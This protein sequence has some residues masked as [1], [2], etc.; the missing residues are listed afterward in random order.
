MSLLLQ[1]IVLGIGATIVI[2]VW[3]IVRRSWPGVSQPN[4]GL[5][6]RWLIGVMRGR[7]RLSTEITSTPSRLELVCGWVAHYAIGIG[8]AGMLLWTA[9]PSWVVEPTLAPALMVGVSTVA[10]P[11]LLM[12]PGM[13]AGIA[14]SRSPAP[15]SAR[16]HSMLT[17][18][19]FGGG[20]YL[21]ALAMSALERATHL[22]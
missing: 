22:A 9:G 17:H 1:S 13:G 6:G 4:F 18:S 10:A 14:A 12:Q 15:W 8:F 2:D 5:V 20:L 11:F 19:I 3:A 7:L 16:F 21:T